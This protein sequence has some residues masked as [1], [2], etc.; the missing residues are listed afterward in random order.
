MFD[1]V[2][3]CNLILNFMINRFIYVKMYD[4]Y[5]YCNESMDVF[6]V[7]MFGVGYVE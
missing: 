1:G 3:C 5:E 4:I 7:L 2:M 6:N